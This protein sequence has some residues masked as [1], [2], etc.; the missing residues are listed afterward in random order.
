MPAIAVIRELK[1]SFPD[2]SI[3]FI[4]GKNSLEEKFLKKEGVP[5]HGIHVGKWRRYF[6]LKNFTDIFRVP[7]GCVEAFKFLRKRK[8]DIVFAKGGYVSFPVGI[9]AKLLGIPLMLHESD[10]TPGLATRILARA[11]KKIFLGLE[12]ASYF[13]LKYQEKIEITG[14]PVREEIFHGEKEKGYRIAGFAG[15][16]GR[17]NPVV[18]IAGGSLGASSLNTLVWEAIPELQKFCRVIHLTGAGKGKEEFP[19][20]DSY[21]P[22]DYSDETLPHLY[23]AAD[24]VVTRAGGSVIAELC[25]LQKPHMLIPLGTHASRGDQWANAKYCAAVFGSIVLSEDG[26]TAQTFAEEIKKSLA[27]F[28]PLTGTTEANLKKAHA[29]IPE[30]SSRLVRG[31]ASVIAQKLVAFT[32]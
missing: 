24:F 31:S 25:A 5:F 16:K 1:K 28:A 15:S 10:A 6:D 11:A 2:V 9:A 23:A 32:A 8:P 12:P 14:T 26:L 4:G 30:L 21:F 18:L 20:T 29:L 22:C 7:I 19:K 3:S 13:L 17:G 27:S